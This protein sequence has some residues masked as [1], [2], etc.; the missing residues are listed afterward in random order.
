M[1]MGRVELSMLKSRAELSM[2]EG[3]AEHAG[4]KN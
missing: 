1:K 4:G 2:L 3:R